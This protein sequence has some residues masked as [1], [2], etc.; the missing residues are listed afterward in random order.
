MEERAFGRSDQHASVVGLGTWQL[1]ADWG[2]V[3]DTEALAVLEAAAESGVTFFDTADVYGDGRSEQTIATFLRS[4][5]DLHVFIATKMGRRVDQI[6]EN[7]VLD[8]FRA[9]NDRSR[10]NLGVDRLDL[11]Q[12]HCPPT[13]VYSSDEV[14]DALDTL[15]EEERVAAYGVSVETCAEALTAIARPNV[16]SVQ[17]ILNPFRMKPLLDVLPA[18]EKAGV[19]IIARVPLAS[20]LLSGKYTKD[21]VFAENDHRTYNRHGESFDQ[22][23]TFSGVDYGTGVEAAVEFAALAPNGYTPAQLALRWIIQLPGVTT[24]IPGARTPDQARANA[25]AAALPELSD[26]TLTA[27]RDLYDRRIKEQVESRW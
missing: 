15:V 21:T 19:A 6:P 26:G 20:G 13:P 8:N 24:V 5:P 7:Y 22:G 23:E 3:D 14:F 18:A 4:R 25:A 12:L 11:V 17:I 2:D 16:A 9:W 1:G 10:R 27:I